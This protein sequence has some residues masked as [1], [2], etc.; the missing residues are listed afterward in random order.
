MFEMPETI[1]ENGEI[2][3]NSIEDGDDDD[4]D[5][6]K[7]EEEG[8]GNT[9]EMLAAILESKNVV[10]GDI[11]ALITSVSGV[12]KDVETL[13]P[14]VAKVDDFTQKY[15]NVEKRLTAVENNTNKNKILD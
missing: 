10:S 5:P 4:E 14:L 11:K 9:K 7:K 2:T 12:Q 15:V 6:K 13:K 3:K 1:Q 8:T